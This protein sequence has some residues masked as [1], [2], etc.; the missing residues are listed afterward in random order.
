MR[1]CKP[2][3]F[4][5]AITGGVGS[6]SEGDIAVCGQPNW[7][8]GKMQLVKF[9]GVAGFALALPAWTQ[10]IKTV[11]GAGPGVAYREGAAATSARLGS[12]LFVKADSAGNFYT[13][14]GAAAI[15]KVTSAGTI[16]TY[17]GNGLAGYS[18][19]GSAATSA[20]IFGN[21]TVQGLAVDNS[22][23]VYFSDGQ[24]QRVR[25]V[26]ASG[27]V[28]TVAGNGT[29]GFSGDG[30]AATS[31][32]VNY[33]NGLAVDS[34][35]NL[36][37]ADRFNERVRK[38]DTTG[39]ISTVAGNGNSGFD[40]DGAQAV[41]ATIG[42]CIGVAVD[43]SGNLYFS[44]NFRIRKV[45]TNGIISTVTGTGSLGYSGDGGPAAG[46]A[47]DPIGIAVNAAGNLYFADAN[48]QRV[49]KI[50]TSGNL[51][52]VAGNGKYADT[53]RKRTRL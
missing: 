22:G 3:A 42:E 36:Y 20:M 50:D 32:M 48:A 31:A 19:D 34:F 41:A 51:T 7:G 8:R 43:G 39:K 1:E 21:G 2:G 29:A 26:S 15:R 17:A 49:R 23:N 44:S 9:L 40:G 37:I 47:G 6:A 18:G 11:A 52:T 30:G 4:G 25:K 24:N 10:T 13:W 53:D 45:S 5:N 38:V 16:T 46:A 28:T 33:P 12:P 27:I 14:D 35:G